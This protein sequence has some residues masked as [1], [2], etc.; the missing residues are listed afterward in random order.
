MPSSTTIR[1]E[2]PYRTYWLNN[3]L[4]RMV[5]HCLQT[6]LVPVVLLSCSVTWAQLHQQVEEDF[7]CPLDQR[8]FTQ[9]IS[10]STR[11]NGLM[12]DMKPYGQEVDLW[13]LPECPGNGFVL[14]KENFSTAELQSLKSLVK[15][16]RFSQQPLYYRAYLM[17]RQVQEPLLLQIRLL[18]QASWQ[19]S[20]QYQQEL[21][22]LLEQL[23]AN[24]AVLS[25]HAHLK[26]L[27][28]KAECERRLGQFAAA[29]R[30]I[31]AA[32]A[33]PE[34]ARKFFLPILTCEKELIVRQ[35]R[36]SSPIPNERTHTAC[37]QSIH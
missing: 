26:Y 8:P 36:N 20:G 3:G 35:A 16:A 18:Q 11:A 4:M 34:D 14:Y 30:S 5:S 15:Q 7:V 21:L 22:Q 9:N 12:L 19:T 1:P 17:A 10:V 33:F 2:S 23:L 13:P 37:G 28:L 29:Q 25:E 32:D 27:L 6:V 24:T 31:E